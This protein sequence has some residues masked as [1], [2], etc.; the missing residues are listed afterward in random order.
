M[1]HEDVLVRVQIIV[2]CISYQIAVEFINDRDEPVDG[3][4]IR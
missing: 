3:L 1:S 4:L 2:F